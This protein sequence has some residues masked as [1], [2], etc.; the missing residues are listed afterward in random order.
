MFAINTYNYCLLINLAL[1]RDVGMAHQTNKT[2]ISIISVMRLH[3]DVINPQRACAAR[4][5]VLSL[6]VFV[7]VCVCVCVCFHEII[8]ATNDTNLLSG[9]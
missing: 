5:T 3:N 2:F 4:V 6:C 9:G 7:C 1:K 8:C